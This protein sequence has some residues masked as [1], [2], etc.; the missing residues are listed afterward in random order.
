MLEVGAEDPWGGVGER[1]LP[2]ELSLPACG[3]LLISTG[4]RRPRG[5]RAAHWRGHRLLIGGK[6]G[7]SPINGQKMPPRTAPLAPGPP[8]LLD[9]ALLLGLLPVQTG[10]QPQIQGIL[11]QKLKYNE[12]FLCR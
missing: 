2:P 9:R 3:I 5:D 8:S 4:L 10:F 1:R 12:V 6:V 7:R 11:M